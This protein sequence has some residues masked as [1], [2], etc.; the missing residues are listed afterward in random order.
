MARKSSN[1]ALVESVRAHAGD[2]EFTAYEDDNGDRLHIKATFKGVKKHLTLDHVAQHDLDGL[3]EGRRSEIVSV[4]LD[5]VEKWPEGRADV[6]CIR[7]EIGL[8]PLLSR[9]DFAVFIGD[10]AVSAG[11]RISTPMS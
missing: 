5:R 4:F 8:K 9:A 3:D 7:D 1:S 2:H 11:V 6:R 10:E